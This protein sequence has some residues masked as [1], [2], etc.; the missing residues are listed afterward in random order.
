MAT[1]VYAI[2][3]IERKKQQFLVSKEKCSQC[4]HINAFVCEHLTPVRD[5]LV[6]ITDP[7]TNKTHIEYSKRANVK[8]E[9]AKREITSNDLRDA[10]VTNRATK[11]KAQLKKG[12]S[13]AGS[14]KSGKEKI[15]EE[16]GEEEEPEEISTGLCVIL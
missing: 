12:R 8:T 7:S 16:G 3:K 1:Q 13:R 11:T 9:E 10:L 6:V 4:K 14:T 5:S 2:K 15:D